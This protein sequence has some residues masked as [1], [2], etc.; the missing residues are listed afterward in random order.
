MRH[1]GCSGLPKCHLCLGGCWKSPQ[2]AGK[3]LCPPAAPCSWLGVLPHHQLALELQT[4]GCH[5]PGQEESP[6][7][8]KPHQ[9][10]LL[11][12]VSFLL[13]LSLDS[14]CEE[15]SSSGYKETDPT[16]FPKSLPSVIFVFTHCQF[17]PLGQIPLQVNLQDSGSK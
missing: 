17:V 1:W 5:T 6:R 2:G 3:S 9:L 12:T 14:P 4:Q 8:S 10:Q 15:L 16:R 7:V 13:S 11:L